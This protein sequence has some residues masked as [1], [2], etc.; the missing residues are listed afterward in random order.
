MAIIPQT[1]LVRIAAAN[2]R[3]VDVAKNLAA[4]ADNVSDSSVTSQIRVQIQAVLDVAKKISD[5]VSSAR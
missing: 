4:T 5:A 2:E 3:L 1:D